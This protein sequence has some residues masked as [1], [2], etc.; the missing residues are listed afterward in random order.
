[1]HK[2]EPLLIEYEVGMGIVGG[3]SLR[4]RGSS[5]VPSWALA[6]PNAITERF[7]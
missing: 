7:T 2:I 5:S 1:M 6:P 4:G 3:V